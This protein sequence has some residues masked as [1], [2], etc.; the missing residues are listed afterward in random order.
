M[1]TANRETTLKIQ[2]S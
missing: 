2:I 1:G